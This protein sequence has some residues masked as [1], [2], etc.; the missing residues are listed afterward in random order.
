[1]LT[2][3]VT[4]TRRDA[5]FLHLAAAG[6]QQQERS[7]RSD[8]IAECVV[9]SGM[10]RSGVLRGAMRSRSAMERTSNSFSEASSSFQAAAMSDTSFPTQRQ[11]Q[12][13]ALIHMYCTSK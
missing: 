13:S 8:Q 1:M 7:S 9:Q 5:C 11:R 2:V 6:A 12:R 10:E 4:V 3:T